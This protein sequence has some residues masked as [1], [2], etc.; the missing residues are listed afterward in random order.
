MKLP[1]LT[2]VQDR[3]IAHKKHRHGRHGLRIRAPHG[4]QTPDGAEDGKEFEMLVKAHKDGD[5]LHLH[6]ADGYKFH[7]PHESEDGDMSEVEDEEA[8]KVNKH[9]SDETADEEG[10]ET[11][12]ETD[13]S[14]D[15]PSHDDTEEEEEE[16]IS[17]PRKPK[18]P[19]KH[20]V[21]E[22]EDDDGE[23]LMS[24]IKK[25]RSKMR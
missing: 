10:E 2:S 4:F 23:S 21:K 1:S 25:F 8:E 24:E 20:A 17:K 9:G 16:V 5:H 11:L 19:V 7:H 13:G 14:E 22:I 6:E 18:S 3:A 15:H 12:E